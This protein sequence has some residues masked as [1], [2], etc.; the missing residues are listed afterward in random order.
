VFSGIG[1]EGRDSRRRKVELVKNGFQP[2]GHRDYSMSLVSA[3][4]GWKQIA[5]F[6]FPLVSARA[7]ERGMKEKE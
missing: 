4:F 6:A 2:P 1:F 7:D 3:R 5:V